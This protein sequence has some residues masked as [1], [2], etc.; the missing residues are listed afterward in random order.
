MHNRLVADLNFLSTTGDGILDKF[1]FTKNDDSR[2]TLKNIIIG[3][4]LT[5]ERIIELQSI[6]KYLL[7]NFSVHEKFYLSNSDNYYLKEYL[8]VETKVLNNKKG[9]KIILS[10]QFWFNK[11]QDYHKILSGIKHFVIIFFEKWNIIKQL[12]IKSMPKTIREIYERVQDVAN[13][14]SLSKEISNKI[15][16]DNISNLELLKLDQKIRIENSEKIKELLF[17]FYNLEAY[18][19]IIKAVRK[20]NYIFPDF[21]EGSDLEIEE[22]YHPLVSDCV[23]NNFKYESGLNLT[24]LTGPNMSGK[25]TL[26]RTLGLIV[27]LGHRGL[28]V[29]AQRVL[30]PYYEGIFIYLNVT[31]DVISGDSYFLVEVKNVV[32]LLNELKQGKRCF[33]IFDEL[34]RGTNYSDAIE[35]SKTLC[36]ELAPYKSSC[37]VVSTHLSELFKNYRLPEMSFLQ[38]SS[39]LENETPVFLYKLK[40]GMSKVHI[41]KILLDKYLKNIS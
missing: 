3:E 27:Y 33:A 25:S 21:I 38:L 32:E 14:F 6:F 15:V 9:G 37:F 18:L 4:A 36:F 30:M 39:R 12:P 5:L 29:P 19:S 23:T 11:P 35:C 8:G 26:L 1:D 24:F 34:F 22:M 2:R 31:D 16:S 7:A 41:G 13:Y 28:P 20:Y 40:T 10:I 17:D